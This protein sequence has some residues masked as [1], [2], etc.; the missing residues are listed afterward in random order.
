MKSIYLKVSN[1][2]FCLTSQGLL[3]ILLKL[4]KNKLKG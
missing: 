4:K 1:F 3:S 2:G